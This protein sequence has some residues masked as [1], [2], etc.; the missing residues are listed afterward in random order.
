MNR[1]IIVLFL[2]LPFVML[3][4]KVKPDIKAIKDIS[5]RILIIQYTKKTLEV[6][7][8]INEALKKCWTAT[9]SVIYDKPYKEV[10]KIVK[11]SPEKFVIL[12][13]QGLLLPAI[14][15][16]HPDV[17]PILFNDEE[18]SI[19]GKLRMSLRLGENVNKSIVLYANPIPIFY[20][21][22]AEVEMVSISF[23]CAIQ[24]LQNYI[25]ATIDPEKYKDLTVYKEWIQNKTLLF[26]TNAL[27]KK[28]L[29][30]EAMQAIYPYPFELVEYSKIEDAILSNS[31]DYLYIR[32][33]PATSATSIF[34]IADAKTGTIISGA[35]GSWNINKSVIER[36]VDLI[37]KMYFYQE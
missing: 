12:Y 22:R 3:S 13:F 23:Y 28:L 19:G 27:P 9:D 18:Y 33:S 26:N 32:R 35:V 21:E 34:S 25:D 8:A 4:Q 30:K 31:N 5:N 29:D 2:L 17:I 11:E 7:K 24:E 1:T 15:R 37:K 20:P 14:M 6:N 36:M 10:R 16:N